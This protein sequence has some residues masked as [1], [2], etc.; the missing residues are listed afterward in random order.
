M[1][2]KKQIPANSFDLRDLDHPFEFPGCVK[3]ILTNCVGHLPLPGDF[4][5]QKPALVRGDQGLKA[6][7]ADLIKFNQMFL[8]NGELD[9]T[10]ILSKHS[11]DAIC[12]NS[13]PV[14]ELLPPFA[15]NAMPLD[16]QRKPYFGIEDDQYPT[17]RALNSYPGQT[18]GLGVAVVRDPSKAGLERSAA[19]TAWWQGIMGTY[20]AFNRQTDIGVL[21]LSQK[22]SCVRRQVALADVLNSAHKMLA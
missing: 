17:Y 1:H 10:R 14:D 7:A 13:L 3:C 2:R 15:F 12:T 8:N 4:C 21:V 16:Q 22:G 18:Y 20:F 19:G 9:G 5:E 11:V 6:S